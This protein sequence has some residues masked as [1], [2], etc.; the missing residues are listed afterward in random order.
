MVTAS[1]V[2][3]AVWTAVDALSSAPVD[4]DGLAG[5]LSWTCWETVEHLADDL[6]CYAA[7]LGP[8]RPPVDGEVP[9][10]WTPRRPGA[11]AN[12]IVADPSS[13][14]SGLLMVLET[15]GAMLSSVVRTCPP[16]TRAHHGYG[17]SD[18]E[19]FAAM[20]VVETLV[21]THDILGPTWTPPDDLCDRVLT[22]LFPDVPVAGWPALLWATGRGDLPN[23]DRRTKWRWHGEPR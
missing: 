5:S 2:D 23:Q 22:R 10:V 13:G 4:W 7:Q 6:F 21:H 19:G 17:A 14:P 3:Q 11:P 12:L 18:P 8:R 16:S 1:D 15:C 20:G 9:F